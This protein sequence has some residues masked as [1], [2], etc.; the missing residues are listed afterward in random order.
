MK[1][2][3][4]CLPIPRIVDIN[5]YLIMAAIQAAAN[6][7]QVIINGLPLNPV[8]TVSAL[9]FLAY[10]PP[11]LVSKVTEMQL[12]KSFVGIHGL[13][14]APRVLLGLGIGR[15]LNKLLNIRASNNWRLRAHNGWRWGEEIAVITGGCS[16]IGKVTVLGLVRKGV[17]VAILDVADLPPDLARLRTVYYF[18][19]DITSPEAVRNAAKKI[20]ETLGHPSILINNAGLANSA[21]ILDSNMDRVNKLF[22]VNLISHWY[23]VKEFLPTMVLR[24]KGHIV[25][26]ASVAS[27][28]ALPTAVEYSAS[29]AAV[30]SFHEG[31]A[32]EIKHIYKAPGVMTTVVHPVFVKTNMTTPMKEEIETRSGKMMEPE[33]VSEA[34]L[35]QIYSCRGAQVFVPPR[36]SWLSGLRGFPNWLQETL[37]DTAGWA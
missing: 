32:S 2:I 3:K 10:G 7:A 5:K 36:I 11:R 20:R 35:N 26:I 29:K 37:R 24:N 30:L 1:S 19:C 15:V 6:A 17:R 23:T 31:L 34:V 21:S 14:V 13:K 8:I 22:Q 12:I 16:G 9:G 4:S 28:V 33:D 25:T 18:K 27:F